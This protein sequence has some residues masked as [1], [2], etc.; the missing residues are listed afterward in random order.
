MTPPKSEYDS[1]IQKIYSVS[2]LDNATLTHPGIS[3]LA[4]SSLS[5]WITDSGASTHMI[6]KSIVF[7][8]FHI[9]FA[10]SIVSADGSSKHITGIGTVNL[11]SSLT[12]TNINYIS[13]VL[14]ILY[15]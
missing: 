7:S 2:T 12:L 8:T 15:L 5:F 9:S 14:L 1:L 11:I 3:C 4:S 13:H 6:S 10:P